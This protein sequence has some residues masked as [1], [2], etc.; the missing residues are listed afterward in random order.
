MLSHTV[1][2]MRAKSNAPPFIEATYTYLNQYQTL[3]VPAANTA[4]Y[5]VVAGSPVFNIQ[6]ASTTN[7]IL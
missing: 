4:S 7:F 2:I 5:S 6:T 1:T 3:A